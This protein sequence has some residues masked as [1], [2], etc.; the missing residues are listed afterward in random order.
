MILIIKFWSNEYLKISAEGIFNIFQ[1]HY[2][3]YLYLYFI[4]GKKKNWYL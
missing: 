3:W 4:K 1:K 2:D